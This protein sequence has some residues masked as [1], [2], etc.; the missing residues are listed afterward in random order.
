MA[1]S[2]LRGSDVAGPVVAPQEVGAELTEARTADLAHHQVDLAAEDVDRL[3]DP[4]Q[5]A[6]DRAVQGR[7]AEEAEL[8]AEAERDQDVG[9]APH[10]AVEHHRYAVANRRLDRRQRVER[11][12]R[13]VELASAM[14]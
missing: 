9:A 4:G 2:L 8:R 10:T 14:V 5:P 6:G 3:L 12:R 13:L 7:P 1:I 11:A